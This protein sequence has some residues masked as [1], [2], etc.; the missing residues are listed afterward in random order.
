[1]ELSQQLLAVG[2][3]LALFLVAAAAA[4]R[5]GWLRMNLPARSRPGRPLELIDRFT[6]T[7]QPQLHLLRIEDRTLLIATHPKGVNIVEQTPAT[8]SAH[9]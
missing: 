2:L 8:L 5:R 3:V 6:L 1:M 4:Q 7:P 9:S